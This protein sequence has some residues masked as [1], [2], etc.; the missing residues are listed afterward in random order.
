LLLGFRTNSAYDRWWE[1]RIIWGAIVNDSRSWVRQL[2]TFIHFENKKS[3]E[4]QLIRDMSLRHVAWNYSLTRH[5]R[6]QNPTQNLKGLISEEEIEKLKGKSNIPNALLFIQSQKLQNAHKNKLIDAY[7]FVQL[8]S[9]LSRL[10]D[11]MG[12]CERIKNTV[13]PSSYSL[14]VDILIYLWI[15]FLPFALV[16]MIGYILI[17]TTISL[18]FSFLVID[19]IAVYMQDPFEN[20]PSDTPM[21]SLSRTIE[22]NI[23]QELNIENIPEPM[24]PESGA[25]M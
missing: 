8:D 3:T 1:A 20:M 7:Q 5:L 15:L 25:L 21:L 6:K 24:K 10:T 12:K 13:F 4:F 23:K 11:S 18:A 19:R 17:P 2:M 9:T 22:I 16:D 14:L